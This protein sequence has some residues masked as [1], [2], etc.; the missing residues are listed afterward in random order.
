ME[1]II[2]EIQ[3]Q[4]NQSAAQMIRSV[5]DDF[6]AP[7]VGTVYS[8]PTTDALYELFNAKDKAIFWVLT[9]EKKVY[10]S[11]GLYPTPGL[12]PKTV[13][14]VKFYISSQARGK[15]Y[16]KKLLDLSISYAQKLEY[17]YIY[18]ETIELFGKAMDMYTQRGFEFLDHTLGE[19]G[20]FA[21]EIQMLKKL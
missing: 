9:D 3:P 21:C 17:D 4:D 13:E 6:D 19:T 16:G 2:R 8:D 15:G 18:L 10:G 20:H 1:L 14:L 7:K 11:C 12:P 5:F